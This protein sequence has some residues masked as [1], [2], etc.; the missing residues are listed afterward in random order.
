MA[1]GEW[2]W[3]PGDFEIDLACKFNSRRYE[4]GVIMPQVWS[5]ASPYRVVSFKKSFELTEPDVLHIA[6]EGEFNVNLNGLFVYDTSGVLPLPCGKYDMEIQVYNYTGVPALKIDSESVVT[7]GSFFVNCEDRKDVPAA[8]DPS[9]LRGFSPNTFRLPVEERNF[10]RTFLQEGKRV[11]DLGKESMAFLRF[12]ADRPGKVRFFYGESPEEACDGEHCMQTD[13]LDCGQGENTTSVCKAFRYL[14]VES[15]SAISQLTALCEYL[16]LHCRASLK[17]RDARLNDIFETS[18]YT[19]QLNS[20]EFFIDGIKRDRWTWGGDFY[21]C[22]LMNYY[23]FF[24]RGLYRRTFRALLGKPPFRHH[25]NH[26]MDYS[27]LMMIS[28]GQYADAAGDTS[29]VREIYPQVREMAM[30]CLSRRDKD[31]LLPGLPGDWVFIDWAEG[32]N[33]EGTVCAEQI[34]FAAALGA[35]EKIARLLREEQDARLF[36]HARKK[37]AAALEI[38]W[39]EER[40]GYFHSYRQGA[41]VKVFFRQDNVFAV[42]FGNCSRRRK[43]RILKN[44]LLSDAVPPIV[45]PY[46]KFYELEALCLLGCRKEV[47]AEIKRYWGKMLDLGATTFWELFDETKQ[48]IEHYYMYGRKYGKSLCHA[49]GAAPLYLLGR[50]F[51]HAEYRDGALYLGEPEAAL[52]DFEAELP[53]PEGDVVRI[54]RRGGVLRTEGRA[55]RESL[56][57]CAL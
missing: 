56:Q 48:G 26:I 27:L 21:Q 39:D 29:F 18:F 37:T 50:Y 32:L 10:E 22:A 57:P 24:D 53:L 14:C 43:E 9:F 42:L 34:L 33:N 4:R 36:G 5:A 40:G 20:R 31:G 1:C 45:T 19:L 17:T 3:Y 44:I 46:F 54:S 13:E 12:H 28:L 52:G 2:I 41:P 6:A 16:P 8:C 35:M 49:W 51:L 11:F 25:I 47:L 23:A 55:V 38:F 7:D 30:F 15:E